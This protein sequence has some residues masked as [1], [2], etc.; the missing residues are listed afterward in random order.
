[1]CIQRVYALSVS[2]TNYLVNGLAKPGELM[3][4]MGASGAGKTCLLNV[5]ASRNLNNMQV[6]GSVRA[7][8]R[9]GGGYR[10]RRQLRKVEEV[11]SEV[12]ELT[13][14]SLTRH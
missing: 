5:L 1:M 6:E 8:L 7:I 13:S 12:S 14:F 2:H 10:S 3:A 4:I 9:M 11:M